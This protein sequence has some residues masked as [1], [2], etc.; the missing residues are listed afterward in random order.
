[1]KEIFLKKTLALAQWMASQIHLRTMRDAFIMLIPFLVLAGMMILVNN[2]I[3][4]PGGILSGF[5]SDT[6]LSSW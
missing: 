5:I 6:T 3:I 4:N 2:V 1:M